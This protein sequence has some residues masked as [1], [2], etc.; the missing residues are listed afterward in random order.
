MKYWA[1]L[2][3]EAKFDRLN[4]WE[5]E[6]EPITKLYNIHH[7]G[8][9]SIGNLPDFAGGF[10]DKDGKP[11]GRGR[12]ATI[13]SLKREEHEKPRLRSSFFLWTKLKFFRFFK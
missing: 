10:V 2:S 4:L 3:A 12:A 6:P 13:E 9:Q 1:S 11:R 7:H 8:T 5:G